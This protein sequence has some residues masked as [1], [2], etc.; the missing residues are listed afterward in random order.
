MHPPS[1]RRPPLPRQYSDVG[2]DDNWQQCGKYGPNGYT[3]HSEEGRPIVNPAR[4][5]DFINMTNYAHSLGLTAGWYGNNVRFLP[6]CTGNR[7][8]LAHSLTPAPTLHT[9]AVHLQRPL[10]RPRV[11]PG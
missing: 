1:H 4:F 3:F 10:Q 8:W 11:L 2:L 9:S 5:P 6:P 7:P